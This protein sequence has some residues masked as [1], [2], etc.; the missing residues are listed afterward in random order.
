MVVEAKQYLRACDDILVTVQDRLTVIDNERYRVE[1][2][3]VK[4]KEEI[5]E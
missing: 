4:L 3:F 5:V 1:S 2:R